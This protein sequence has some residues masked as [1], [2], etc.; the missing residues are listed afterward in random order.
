MQVLQFSYNPI[1]FFCFEQQFLAQLLENI[2]IYFEEQNSSYY[3]PHFLIRNSWNIIR[4]QRRCDWGKR[5]V[6]AQDRFS[7]GLEASEIRQMC[8]GGLFTTANLDLWR[9]IDD[10]SFQQ[11]QETAVL[12]FMHFSFSVRRWVR[13]SRPLIRSCHVFFTRNQFLYWGIPLQSSGQRN[14][15]VLPA[16]LIRGTD[17][18]SQ[19]RLRL[20]SLGWR[21]DVL[22]GLARGSSTLLNFQNAKSDI[23]FVIHSDLPLSLKKFL[24]I[25]ER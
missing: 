3:Q 6:R 4:M 5:R 15:G 19:G 16:S 2:K 20:A 17:W 11:E 21:T 1:N 13:S 7:L 23:T 14:E 10:L 9:R 12:S 18:E 24:G 8:S 25:N 22:P